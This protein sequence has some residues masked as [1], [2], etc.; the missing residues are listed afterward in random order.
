MKLLLPQKNELLKT[1][2][3]DYYYWNYSFP[4]SAI[5]RYRFKK[6]IKFLG[7]IN[8][9]KLLEIGI[10]SGIFLPELSKHTSELYGCDIHN[11]YDNV[12]K[13]C[14]SYNIP[15]FYIEKQN[16]MKTTYNSKYFDV[17]V[18]VSVLEF[19]ENLQMA[20][21]EIKRILKKNGIFITLTP[22]EN[23]F[24]DWLL[25]FYTSKKPNEEFGDSRHHVWK[26]LEDNFNIIHK[27]YLTP[28]IGKYFPV[29][30]FYKLQNK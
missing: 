28:V 21:D 20:I 5:Q 24:T 18:G 27:E 23:K 17:I 11:N 12:K 2:D 25:S 8:Y 3:V 9:N 6:V 1:G 16:I 13:L 29:Y 22:M 15:K 10:G 26:R 19:V 30:T 14:K 7:D 4:I